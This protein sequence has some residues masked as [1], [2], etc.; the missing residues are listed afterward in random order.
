M[1][2]M[3]KT[4]FEIKLMHEYFLTGEDGSNLFSEP[5]P[6][7]RLDLLEQAYGIDRASID[8][9]MAF[10][11]PESFKPQYQDHGLKILPSY[12]GCKVLIR[13]NKIILPDNSVVYEPF[14][15]IPDL[16]EI[17]ILF[18]KKN[19]FPNIYS[20]ERIARSI[21]SLYFFS[22][23]NI[24]DARQFPFLVNSISSFD[25]GFPY[26]HGEMAIDGSNKLQEYYYDNTGALQPADVPGSVQ[27]FAN[28]ND[29]MLVPLGFYYSPAGKDPVTQL[30]I[31][32]KDRSGNPVKTF[33]F[34]QA[35]PIKKIFLDFSELAD[36]LQLSTTLSLPDGL[37]S[38]QTTGNNGYS[39][40]KNIV[41]SDTCYS[42]SN[43]GAA[44]IKTQVTNPLFQLIEND[45]RI[46][47]RFDN[48]G[49]LTDAP[50]FEIPVK[51]RYGNFRYTNNN[52]KELTLNPT[53]NN[54]LNKEGKALISFLPVPLCKYYFLVPGTGGGASKYLPNP[55]SYEM[56]KD[57]LQRIYFDIPVPESDLFPV[58]P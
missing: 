31:T 51:S 5:D 11:F 34:S 1:A 29:R 33:S 41:F 42:I 16:L 28:E 14:F 56:K 3:Y 26:E 10:D 13:V 39:D 7:K 30:D 32:L 37:F 53:L 49:N 44:Y 36:Q 57:S 21:P 18:I 4:L 27:S 22:N 19:N 47:K 48:L 58:L 9:D 8:A 2:L 17:F 25:A 54:F 55:R 12:G 35:E 20:N 23:E 46:V 6:K 15:A 50:V 40:V 45:G 24:P 38:L 43:W 52:G